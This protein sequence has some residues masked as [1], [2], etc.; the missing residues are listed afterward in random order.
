MGKSVVFK[1]IKSLCVWQ[2][3]F[4]INFYIMRYVDCLLKIHIA[5]TYSLMFIVSMFLILPTGT[6]DPSAFS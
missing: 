2:L 3:Y 5:S 4:K 6:G 1:I